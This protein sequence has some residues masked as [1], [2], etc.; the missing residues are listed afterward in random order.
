MYNCIYAFLS[1]PNP[2][3]VQAVC[4]IIH[5]SDVSCY[6]GKGGK[7]KSAMDDMTTM[8]AI[9]VVQLYMCMIGLGI[10][11]RVMWYVC[12]IHCKLVLGQNREVR[13]MLGTVWKDMLDDCMV[14]FQ[15][16]HGSIL[17]SHTLCILGMGWK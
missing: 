4:V 10:R 11:G 15:F 1:I 13:S 6:S 3:T 16:L 17:P 2:Q 12:V 8:P 7:V 9:A 14:E 5:N